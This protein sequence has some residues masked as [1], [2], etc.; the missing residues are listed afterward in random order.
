ME[1]PSNDIRETKSKKLSGITIVLGV[2][3]S[4]AAV[5]TVKLVREL[6][7]HGADIYP[8]LSKAAADI[9][10]PYALE[11]A[12][13]HEAI[14]H[15]TGKVEH[16]ALAGIDKPMDILLIAPATANTISKVACAIDDTPVTTFATTA[17]GSGKKVLMVPAMHH[18]MYLHPVVKE[19][20]EK[21]K[22]IGVG[23]LMPK[24]EENKAKLPSTQAIVSW[25]IR[26]KNLM[27]HPERENETV[28]LIGG[29]CSEPLDDV[30]AI[31]NISSGRSAVAL[32]QA[33]FEHGYQLTFLYGT[34]QAPVPGHIPRTDF[35]SMT[36]LR[37]KME[38]LVKRKE[39]FA[40]VICV[41]ALPDFTPVVEK[42]SGKISSKTKGI[43]LT[44]KQTQKLL[45]QLRTWFPDARLVGYKLESTVNRKENEKQMVEKARKLMSG[46][47]CDLV[48]ANDLAN[49]SQDH[50]SV[51]VLEKGK[52]SV[53]KLAGTKDELA[54]EIFATLE[55]D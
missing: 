34:S 53:K 16:V 8:V 48:V 36:D 21:L 11:F 35:Q 26:Q 55:K 40:M 27:S 3:G 31:T 15:I 13:G 42:K 1:H 23:I 5:E 12:S 18:S 39:K 41:A 50:S 28:L 7:R 49:V 51:H 44:L 46:A 22:E 24:I 19:N 14:T 43:T 4:I 2:T 37:R 25:V 29:A 52:K 32:A 17:I 54:E 6:I 20:I 30:R 10:H 38:A 33:A 47:G 9:I 45:P